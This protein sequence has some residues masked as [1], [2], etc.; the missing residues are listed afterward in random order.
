MAWRSAFERQCTFLQTVS[1]CLAFDVL[2]H[3]EVHA[4]LAADVVERADVRMIQAGDSPRLALEAFFEP[5]VI[6]KV[7]R[8]NLDGDGAIKASVLG[9]VDF[10]HSTRADGRNNLIW[11]KLG[12]RL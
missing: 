8:K 9:F 1:Q 4:V 7:R 10:T 3:H 5:G 2:H 12:S 11:P 6:G